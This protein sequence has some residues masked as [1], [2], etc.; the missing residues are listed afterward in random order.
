V[1]VGLLA[2]ILAALPDDGQA[3]RC[4]SGFVIEGDS[5]GKVLVECGPPTAKEVVGTKTTESL[6]SANHRKKSGKVE[7]WTYNCGEHDFIYVLTFEGGI[8]KKEETKGY[9]KG[10]SDCR[11]KR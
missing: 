10:N 2:F 1:S 4:G 9:G 6:G 3:F 5:V 11:G 8:L 7:K